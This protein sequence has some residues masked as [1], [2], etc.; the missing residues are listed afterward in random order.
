MLPLFAGAAGIFK[1]ALPLGFKTL[2]Y[3]V[4]STFRD[5]VVPVPGS[6]L[7]CDLWVAVE[8]SGIYVGDGMVVHYSGFADWVHGLKSSLK[9]VVRKGD[10]EGHR[11]SYPIEEVPL[12]V[13]TQGKGF[14]IKNHPAPLFTGEEIAQR[15]RSRIGESEYSV[16]RN[17]CEHFC[18]WCIN[19]AHTSFQVRKV[20]KVASAVSGSSLA[21]VA[22]RL[23]V[24]RVA[25]AFGGGAMLGV[26]APAVAAVATGYSVYQAVKWVQNRAL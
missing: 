25:L 24:P 7:Y 1:A 9:S 12:D 23:A 26:T 17:N 18:E 20:A 8:H 14:T 4:D 21:A 2:K 3:F 19:D 22:A 5:K 11:I 13:F 10:G 15:A 6:V 16:I